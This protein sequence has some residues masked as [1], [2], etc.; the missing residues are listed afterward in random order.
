MTLLDAINRH[1]LIRRVLLALGTVFIGMVTWWSA[2]FA[3][4]APVRYDASGVALII[5]AVQAPCTLLF[6]HLVSLYNDARKEKSDGQ[7]QA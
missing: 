4:H 6:G 5:A 2:W 7:E 3:H 1:Q